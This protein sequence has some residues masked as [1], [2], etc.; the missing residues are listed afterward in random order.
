MTTI[1]TD[2]LIAGAG[3]SGLSAA[4][5]LEKKGKRNYLLVEKEPD[6]GGLCGSFEKD[7]YTFDWS[8]H[9]LHLHTNDGMKLVK[10]LLGSN[11]GRLE[12]S[13]WIYSHGVCTKYP[14]QAALYGLPKDVV[15]ECVTG[16]VKSRSAG[17]AP[18]GANF[19]DWALA[20]FGEGICRHFMFPYNEKLWGV[21]SKELG[22][23]WCAPFVPRPSLDEIIRGA[24]WPSEKQ[25]GYNPSF[26]YPLRGGSRALCA[27][28]AKHISNLKLGC[29][30]EKIDLQT[31][32]AQV[33]GLGTVSY[34]KLINTL[35]LK[36]TAGML[37]APPAEIRKHAA[38]LRARRVHVV[39]LGFPCK[40][41]DKHWLY[42]PEKQFPFYRA[43]IASNF[44]PHVA[45]KGHC[46]LYIEIPVDSGSP[47]NA[48]LEKQA[49]AGLVRCGLLPEKNTPR[50]DSALHLDI[51]SAYA[52]YDA[53]RAPAVQA[54][55]SYLAK[56]SCHCTGRYGLWR[57]SFM[58]QDLLDARDLA[59][60]LAR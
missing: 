52:V 32:T 16:A 58:E 59:L 29:A 9:L 22:S 46:S 31:R 1:K 28:L 10:S 26:L 49:V 53:R 60:K 13:A 37:D 56:H 7:G 35:P 23:D 27:A 12:R 43:G 36:E 38:A 33:K 2:I 5:H 3:I 18:S 8:G 30:V 19:H 48:A 39:N 47:D 24:Y 55:T 21:P 40:M 20:L 42:F 15:T 45:P 57:Y 25:Y 51:G 54:L 17:K 11:I 50:P 44:S 14:F 34:K 41:P 6:F 4:Y